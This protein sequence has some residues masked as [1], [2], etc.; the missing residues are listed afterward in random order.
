MNKKTLIILLFIALAILSVVPESFA[1]PQYLNSYNE[2]YGGGSCGTCHIRASGGGPRNAYGTLFENQP[3]HNT[4]PG[5][6]LTAIGPLPTGASTT[7]V[8]DPRQKTTGERTPDPGLNVGR[9]LNVSNNWAGYV[10]TG[11]TFSS[12]GGS[13]IIPQVNTTG[14]SSDATWVGIGGVAS[15]QLIQTGTR[16]VVNNNAQV[17][18]QAWY[19]ILPAN[20]QKIPLSINPGDYITASIAQ[21][22]ANQWTISLSDIT[23]GQNYQTNVTY[24]SSLSSAEWIVE[25]PVL[26]R[27]F[28]PLDNFGSVQF[29]ALSTVKDGTTLTPAQANAQSIVMVNQIGQVLAQPSELGSDG[30]SFTITRTASTSTQLGTPFVRS[31]LRRVVIRGH[32]FQSSNRQS[33]S[34]GRFSGRFEQRFGE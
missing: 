32:G 14:I 25:M 29:N 27:Y 20:S 30:A 22:S 8:D 24:A 13:W 11:G 7:Q 33:H 6:A 34:R 4:D 1:L 9:G 28:I 26:G 17:S 23:T 31:G 2:V 10:A 18:Y 5:A 16:A 19:E 15:N 12:V 3:D 21:Q